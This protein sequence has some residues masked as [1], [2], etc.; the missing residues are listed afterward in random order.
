MSDERTSMSSKQHNQTVENRLTITAEMFQRHPNFREIGGL[1][2]EHLADSFT[3]RMERDALQS[4]LA[5]S[6]A[7]RAGLRSL[8]CNPL[9]LWLPPD[10]VTTALEWMAEQ[11]IECSCDTVHYE[12]DTNAW[13]HGDNCESGLSEHAAATLGYWREFM[14]AREQLLAATS[15]PAGEPGQQEAQS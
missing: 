4:R 11:E 5:A 8:L 1:I 10:A 12:R 6:E 9:A 15:A 7:A 13:V 2:H 3:L 14:A